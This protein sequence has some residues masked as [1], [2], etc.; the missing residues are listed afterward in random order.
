MCDD[1][2]C[3]EG[4]IFFDY[5]L[6]IDEK[7]KRN[8]Q[9]G[10]ENKNEDVAEEN[11]DIMVRQDIEKD[12]VYNFFELSYVQQN[13][14][15]NELKLLRSEYAGKRYVEIIESILQD[16]R[17]NNCLEQMKTLIYAKL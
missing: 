10:S 12:I 6:N 3:N 4:K 11:D 1:K 7:R 5:S 14:V 17:D 15:L 16:A 2:S 8:L 13:E 9:D